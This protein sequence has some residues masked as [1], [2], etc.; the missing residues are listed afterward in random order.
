[1]TLPL[2]QQLKIRTMIYVAGEPIP[3]FWP[4]RSFIH[5]NPL[6]GLEHLPFSEAVKT[7]SQLF[8]GRGFLSR[9]EYQR[10]L[11]QDKV[12]RGALAAGID[13]FVAQ[14]P[15]IPGVDLSHWLMTLLTRSDQPIRRAASLADAKDVQAVIQQTEPPGTT[16]DPDTLTATL[17]DTLLDAC[18]LYEAVDRLYGTGI[19]AE[20]DEL[21]IKSC[22]DFF[23][24]GQSVWQMPG[25]KQGLFSAWREL[26]LRNARL[27]MRG[28]HIERILENEQHPEGV[29]A[30]VMSELGIPEDKWVSCFSRELSR[31]HGWAGFI[32]WRANAKH[33]YW[34]QRYPADLVDFLAIRLTL[35]LALLAERARQR[36]AT[37]RPALETLIQ[38]RPRETWLRHE[39]H[40]GA[41]LPAYAQRV[42]QTLARGRA[43]AIEQCF[44]DYVRAKRRHDAEDQADRLRK[45]AAQ[46][47]ASAALETLTPG[48]LAELMQVLQKFEGEEGMLWLRAM[49][50][51]AMDAV[52]R[53]VNL[54][55]PAPRDKRPFAQ[56]L[57]CIDTRSER[58]RRQL[59]H[60][61]DYQTF[62]IAGF[63]G[64]PISFMELGK[65]SETHLCPVLLKPKNL[66]LEMTAT[67]PEDVAATTA[68]EKVLHELKESVFT[69][70]VTVEAIG[71]L[72]GFDM[73][74]K[75]FMPQSYNRW[76]QRLF[77]DKPATHLLLDKLD[78]EQADSIVRAVQR[79]V[80][81]K[82]VEQAFEL[83]PEAVTDDMVRELR[84][85]ALGHAAQAPALREAVNLSDEAEQAF[86]QRLR[87]V[88]RI[89]PAFARL[90]M[91]Q[92]ARIGFSLDEQT[93]FVSQ[94]LHSIGLNR[95]FSRFILLVGHGSTSE[96][97]PYESAL[98]CGACGGNHG[99]IN[100][101]AL[102]QMGNKPRVRQRLRA[103][104]IEIPDDAWFLPALHDT[105]TDE[106]KLFDLDRLPSSHVVYLDRLRS[107]LTGASRMCAQERLP[108]LQL[109]AGECDPAEANRHTRRNAM[110]WSQVRPEWGL[111]GNAYFII[112]RRQLTRH[113][114]LEGRAFLHSYDY[115]A[116]PKQR[117]LE[118]ILTGPLVVGQWINMEHYFSTV[119]NERFGSGSKVYH[120]VAGRF[121]VMTGNLSDLRTGLP[122]QTVLDQGQ[123]YHQ[124]IRLIT[125]IEAPYEHARQA[126][127]AVV[128]IK[129]LVRNGWVR[130]LIIDPDQNTAHIYDQDD[131]HSQSL[132][133]VNPEEQPT[134]PTA[135]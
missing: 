3:F 78:R 2:G 58:I 134:E 109:T 99:L 12:D 10:Y 50:A 86:I 74:G 91:E 131:W 79:A 124:P 110:D 62:G 59:E 68:L 22:L 73:I 88:Y 105:T 30:S 126:I 102:A 65:G 38:T 123:P 116:D 57:F 107:G 61:G 45:L 9:H 121:G 66:V 133:D 43:H 72:F 104:G 8:H 13:E 53:E 54:T 15:V 101:R 81:A 90:Q 114:S 52:L 34:S 135:S 6:H 28:L 76:R 63:F 94:A 7:G 93:N 75:T 5:H 55:P 64:V 84:E 77:R 80:V 106:I 92:L 103:Q 125:V 132:P 67:E 56:A 11:A 112:G 47:D 39:L 17:R 31:L 19:G 96:N 44:D 87:S 97:N 127:E 20:L 122:A 51:H 27:F 23:D 70:Y 32:R 60:A 48:Q 25:R 33:Y 35:G 82:A 14:Q 29:I 24:E 118:S 83:E 95:D 129:N 18:P 69:P 40:S 21:V 130:L 46:T 4:M 71:M 115:R 100:A 89:E 37:D 42:E 41:I 26:A 119:D 85:T 49:E 36:I 108:E 120:N 117:L 128:T 98:D 16:I 111:S 1:M 113:L